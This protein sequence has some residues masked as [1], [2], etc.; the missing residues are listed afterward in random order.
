MALEPVAYLKYTDGPSST[1]R[2]RVVEPLEYLGPTGN[3]HDRAGLSHNHKV[4]VRHVS[5]ILP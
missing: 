2:H 5:E 3:A 1:D 4:L